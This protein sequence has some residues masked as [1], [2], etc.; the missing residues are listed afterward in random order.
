MNNDAAV[1]NTAAPKPFA[2]SRPCHEVPF[3]QMPR[4]I[5]VD[6]VP[7]PGTADVLYR[8]SVVD[9][10]EN[11]PAGSAL[12]TSSLSQSD[13]IPGV[14]EGGVKTWECAYDL[15]ATLLSYLPTDCTG[16][17]VL[18]VC[19]VLARDLNARV[20]QLGCGSALPALV[21]LLRNATVCL[22][23]YVHSL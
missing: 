17:R 9:V 12:A 2:F 19:M 4:A 7:L 20:I 3:V 8:R 10:E 15:V 21:A 14:Y 11:V 6:R 22:Q 18:E 23:D 13:L 5:G 16:L 1:Q